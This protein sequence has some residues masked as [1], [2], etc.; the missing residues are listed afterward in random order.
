MDPRS[1]TVAIKGVLVATIVLPWLVKGWRS[2][3]N[4]WSPSEWLSFVRMAHF[5]DLGG[6]AAL[7]KGVRIAWVS[8]L[9]LGILLGVVTLLDQLRRF[10]L[11]APIVESP[12][13]QPFLRLGPWVVLAWSLGLSAFAL[14]RAR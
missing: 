9:L 8:T 5:V 6:T 14:S 13:I 2:K 10:G 7:S 1:Q 12:R 3:R 4:T 11:D